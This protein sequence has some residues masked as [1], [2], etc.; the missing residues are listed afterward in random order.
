MRSL[1]AAFVF[2]L[3][4]YSTVQ[5][6]IE[7]VFG[8]GQHEQPVFT[9][10][11]GETIEISI[12]LRETGGTSI[13]TN[14]GLATAGTGIR[15]EPVENGPTITFAESFGSFRDAIGFERLD[16]AAGTAEFA[17]GSL[18]D[19]FAVDGMIQIGTVSFMGGT[20]GSEILLSTEDPNDSVFDDLFLTPSGTV[21][22]GDVFETAATA[23][24]RT[25]AV[26]EPSAFALL[27]FLSAIFGT[28]VRT[29]GRNA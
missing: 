2:I 4:P 28:G 10:E 9:V 1:L 21:L 18:S 24:V 8:S 11:S 22:D 6:D 27:G 19:V 3:A 25:S 5:A 12:F 29:R 17:G 13:L 16:A 26:P 7:L 20:P 15:F 23:I 14:E